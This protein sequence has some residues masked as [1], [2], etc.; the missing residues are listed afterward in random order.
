MMDRYITG[1]MIKRLRENK[2]ITQSTLA[3]M[4]NVSDKTV[5][6]WETCK[7]YPD[8]TL[9]EPIAAALGISVPELLTGNNVTNANRAANML[10]TKFYV[11]PVCGNIIHAAG[12]AVISCH[13]ISLPP[14]ESEQPDEEHA[15]KIEKSEDEYYISFDHAMTREHHISFV[16][17]E[18]D[19]AVELIKFYP[20]GNAECRVKISRTRYISFYCNKDGLFRMRVKRC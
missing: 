12:E 1:A 5:S 10:R 9:I 14:L 18:A 16:A 7:G 20:E 6:K 4:L 17:A 19:N 15:P 2:K 3:E 8:I 11:C 13:G